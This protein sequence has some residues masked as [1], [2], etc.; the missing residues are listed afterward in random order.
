MDTVTQNGEGG[1]PSCP[2]CR[3]RINTAKVTDYGSFLKV[4]CPEKVAETDADDKVEDDEATASEESDNSSDDSIESDG[5]D[6]GEDLQDFIVDDNDEI[7]YDDDDQAVDGD[8]EGNGLGKTPFEKSEIGK[9]N[10]ASAAVSSKKAKATKKTKK[11]KQRKGKEKAED[12]HKSLAQLR[13]EGLKNKAAKK[14]YLKRLKK[15]WQTSAKIEKTLVSPPLHVYVSQEAVMNL[16]LTFHSLGTARE[17]PC[18]RHWRENYH[19]QWLHVFPRPVGGPP[20][21]TS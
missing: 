17:H 12:N 18:S 7:E 14:K 5:E 16:K 8:D 21:P 6:N 1:E 19:I 15:D 4:F 10:A 11:S 3:S 9:A 20:A 2:H 13:R